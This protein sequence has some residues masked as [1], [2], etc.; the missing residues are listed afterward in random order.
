[1]SYYETIINTSCI[2]FILTHS[3]SDTAGSLVSGVMFASGCGVGFNRSLSFI[4]STSNALEARFPTMS[5]LVVGSGDNT[6]SFWVNL[7][8]SGTLPSGNQIVYEDMLGEGNLYP[9]VWF[10]S[11]SINHQ[12]RINGA[13]QTVISADAGGDQL[14]GSWNNFVVQYDNP[15]SKV[16]IWKNGRQLLSSGTTAGSLTMGAGSAFRIGRGKDSTINGYFDGY[17]DEFRVY[18][19]VLASGGIGS[20][21]EKRDVKGGLVAY[22]KF[23]EAAGNAVATVGGL[24]LT[25]TGA[26]ASAAGLVVNTRTLTTAGTDYFMRTDNAVFE[27]GAGSFTVAFWIKLASL[28]TEGTYQGVV[29]K[30]VTAGSGSWGIEESIRKS[31]NRICSYHLRREG[32]CC[33]KTRPHSSI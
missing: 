8:A 30:W 6:V 22:Y 23:D 2:C 25:A 20:L 14:I 21:A 33:V 9:R 12:F 18:N 32:S 3:Y 13:T 29:T 27:A 26:P 5:G 24:D 4:G 19:T 11:G 7:N 17:I 10:K 15:N 28:P 16:Y 1:M 31:K